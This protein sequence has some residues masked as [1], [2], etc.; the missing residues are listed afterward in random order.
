MTICQLCN[1]LLKRVYLQNCVNIICS[2][3]NV[4]KKAVL[5]IEKRN[6]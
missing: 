1:H 5:K 3:M 2:E 4:Q 6:K